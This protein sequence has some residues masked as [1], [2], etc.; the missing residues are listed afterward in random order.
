MKTFFDIPGFT[1]ISDAFSHKPESIGAY[2]L[3][4]HDFGIQDFV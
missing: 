1:G 4:I 2:P 3:R